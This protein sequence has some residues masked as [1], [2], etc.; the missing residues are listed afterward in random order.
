MKILKIFLLIIFINL[1]FIS[2]ED[3]IENNSTIDELNSDDNLEEDE[4]GPSAIIRELGF[5]KEEFLTHKEMRIIYEKIFF[6]RELNEKEKIFFE[7]M[8]QNILKEIPD[9][10][11]KNDIKK[12]F[13]IPFLMKFMSEES[14]L[15]DTENSK[16]QKDEM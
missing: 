3:N 15:G 13:D 14:S 2:S 11:E 9:K 1:S 10:I 6:Q 5:D 16:K 7:N 8:I 4:L 12:Y